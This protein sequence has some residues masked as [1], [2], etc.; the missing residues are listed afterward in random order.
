[1]CSPLPSFTVSIL[2][3]TAL[4]SVVWV[5]LQSHFLE[6]DRGPNPGIIA[7][8]PH[9]R[10]ILYQLSHKGSPNYCI[11]FLISKCSTIQTTQIHD[12]HTFSGRSSYLPPVVVVAKS[13]PM[14]CKPMDCST[15][16]SPVLHH[17]P[18]S[19]QIPLSQ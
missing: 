1:M 17:L 4:I 10:Q 13:C 5:C 3:E 19:A 12:M 11:I 9:C 7:M 14:L 16:G 15:T 8:S 6:H 18:E 2:S